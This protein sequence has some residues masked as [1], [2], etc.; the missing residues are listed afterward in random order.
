MA[1]LNV[2]DYVNSRGEKNRHAVYVLSETPDYL[3]GIDVNKALELI[4]DK[5]DENFTPTKE[6]PHSPWCFNLVRMENSDEGVLVNFYAKLYELAAAHF[7]YHDEK[8][9][10]SSEDIIAVY[11][12]DHSKINTDYIVNAIRESKA[13]SIEAFISNVKD[14]KWF[15]VVDAKSDVFPGWEEVLSTYAKMQDVLLN[16]DPTQCKS[17]QESRAA[18]KQKI[19]GFDEEWMKAFK[20][21]KKSGI[22]SAK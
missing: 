13:K 12:D 17:L 6:N 22:K 1:S 21:F 5:N 16:R 20:N 10:R 11:N 7:V 18:G 2:F 19:E 8:S 4:V 14:L 15:S 9:D 3:M